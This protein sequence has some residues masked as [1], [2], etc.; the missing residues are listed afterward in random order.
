MIILVHEQIFKS[1]TQG[2]QVNFITKYTV[3]IL[4]VWT[5]EKIAV[6]IPKLEQY[7]FTTE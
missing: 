4:K 7:C 1:S 5:S 2:L 3:K 6:I